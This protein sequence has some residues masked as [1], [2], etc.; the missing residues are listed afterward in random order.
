[1]K[2]LFALIFICLTLVTSQAQSPIQ[3]GDF[4]LFGDH[5]FVKLSVDDSDPLDFILDTGDGLTVIDLDIAQELKLPMD[6]KQTT[7]SAQGSIT[8]ALI[9]HNKIE[10]GDFVLEKNIKVYAT[11]LD[12]L[13]ISIGRNI[14]GIIGYDMLH[15]HVV[16]IDY[17]QM[18]LEVYDSGSYPKR[19]EELSFKFHTAIPVVTASVILNNDQNLEGNFFLNTGAGTTL[20]FNTPFANANGI[21]DKTG[22]HY[23]Y[24]VKGLGKEETRHY[25]GRVKTLKLG[26]ISY[27]NVPIGISQV[28]S[29]IQGDKKIS[30][31]IGNKIL[32]RYNILFDYKTHKIYLEAN[33][34]DQGD[35]L[36]NCSGLDVQ[37]STDMSKVL[38]HQVIAGSQAEAAG[39]KLNDEILSINGSDVSELTLIDVENMLKK[40]GETV[41][42]KLNSAGTMKEVSLALKSLL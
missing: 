12:H 42:I 29:G 37:L 18:K 19:G 3:T 41:S 7:T 20:D 31:I 17:D 22:E 34:R 27:D 30:G 15:H 21:I 10:L 14:D 23:S 35:F 36:V 32:S 39:I 11:D 16:R 38:V 33:G 4:E 28:Q 40:P 13:E 9:K 8:G 5:I 26:N 6:H 2:S 25:E 1:M 24:L